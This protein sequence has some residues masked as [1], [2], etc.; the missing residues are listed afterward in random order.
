MITGEINIL[1]GWAW[2]CVGFLF[3]MIL[4]L[5]A[6]GERWLGGYASLKRRYLR[7]SHVAFIALSIV[8]ILYG[9][10]ISTIDLPNHFENIGS[11]LMIFGAVGVPLGCISAASFWR[12]KYF[13]P[14]PAMAVLAGIIILLIGLV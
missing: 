6:E 9:R 5:R 14:L 7:L 13:L 3:G 2:M 8:N 1:F 11:T 12:T 4:G 10:E